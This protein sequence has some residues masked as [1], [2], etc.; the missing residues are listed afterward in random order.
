M[1]SPGS[2]PAELLWAGRVP[3]LLKSFFCIIVPLGFSSFCCLFVALSLQVLLM[4][5]CHPFPVEILTNT[6]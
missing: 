5:M 4:L 3:A 1:H 6:G 2:F